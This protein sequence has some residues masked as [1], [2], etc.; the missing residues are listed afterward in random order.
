VTITQVVNYLREKNVDLSMRG[1]RLVV[2]GEDRVVDEPSLLALLREHKQGLIEL[3]QSGVHIGLSKPAVEVPPNQIPAAGCSVI[4]PEMLPLVELSAGQIEALLAKVPGGVTN[5]QDIYPLAPLQE[6]ILFHYLVEGEGDPYLGSGLMAFDTKE[7][8]NRYLEAMQAV[9]NRH[10]ILRTCIFWSGLP[11]PV[12]VVLRSATPQVEEVLLESAG[13]AARQLYAH[14]DPRHF[15]LD[16][17]Q[18]PLLRNFIAYDAGQQRWLLLILQHHLLGDHTTADALMEEVQAHLLGK[19][20]RLPAPLPFRNLVAQARLGVSQEEHEAFFRGMLGD[21]DEPTIPFG[22]LEVQG[23]GNN[24]LE[25]SL[26]LDS[27]LARSMREQTRRLGVSVA[28]LC[29]LAWG[30]VLARVSGRNDVVFGT[31]LFGRMEAGIGGRIM[32]PFINTLPLRLRI[33]SQCVVDGVRDTHTLLAELL[34]HEH[35]PLA[36]AQRCSAV[37]APTPLF[38]ALLNYYR[39]GIGLSATETPRIKGM[40]RVSAEERTNYPFSLS[41]DDLGDGLRLALQVDASIDPA[42]ICCFMQTALQSL[43]SAIEHA[44][45]TALQ[46]LDVLPAEERRQVL[47]GW[48]DTAAEYR[49]DKCVHQLFEEQ[50]ERAPDAVALVFEEQELSYAQLNRQA[51]RLANHL[52]GLGVGPNDRVAIYVERSVAM[53]VAMLAVLKAGGAYVPLDPSYPA[54]RLRF[55]LDDSRPVALLTQSNFADRFVHDKALPVLIF[56]ADSPAWQRQPDNN[57]E[58]QQLTRDHLAYVIYTSGSTGSPKGVMIQHRALQNFFSAMDQTLGHDSS[59]SPW[60]SVTSFSFDISIL[61]I[62][63]PLT[64]GHPIELHSSLDT[65]VRQKHRGKRHLQCTPSFASALVERLGE[66]TEKPLFKRILIGGEKF[67]DTLSATLQKMARNGV[68]NMYGPTETTI[69]SSVYFCQQDA[70]TRSMPIGKPIANTQIYILDARGEPAPIGVAGELHIG[71]DGVARGYLNQPELTAE[72]FLNDPFAAQPG[73]RMYR[74]GDLGRWLPDGN[75][76]LLGRNDFQV[77]LRGFRIELGEIEARLAQH[78]AVREAVV[79]VRE[80]QPGDKRLVAYLVPAD[81]QLIPD[82]ET[83]RTHLSVTLPDYMVPAAYVSLDALPLTPNGKLDRNA[84]A[85]PDGEAYATRGYAPPQRQTETILAAIWSDVLHL[86]RVGRHDNFFDL[87]GHSLL[88]VRVITKVQQVLSS[89]IAIS[90]LFAHPVL[91]DLARNVE[92]AGRSNLPPITLAERSK[93]LPLSFAQQRLWFLAQMDGSSETY[94]IPFRLRLTGELNGTALRSALD[95]IKVRHEAL[96]TSFVLLDGEP[97]QRIAPANESPFLLVEHDL[98]QHRDAHVELARL[99]TLETTAGFFLDAGPLIRGR[100]VRLTHDEYA[101]LITMHHIVSD[102]WSMGIFINELSTLYTA[103]LNGKADPLPRLDI[104]YADYAV[105]QR[106]WIEGD[107]LQRQTEYWKTLADAPALLELAT[108]HPRPAQRN[109]AGASARLLLDEELTAGLKALSARHGTTLF[110]TLLTG[111]AVLLARLSGQKDVVIGTPTANRGRAEIEN[112]IGFFVN[113]LALR[114][115]LSSS[116]TVSALLA[117][118]KARV[119]SAQQHQDIPFEQVVEIAQPARSLAHTPLFQV[120]FVWQNPSRERPT[121]PGLEL[122]L[123]PTTPYVVA[124]FDLTLSLQEAESRITGELEYATSLFDQSTIERYVVYFRTLLEAMAT[125]DS[126]A[127]DRLR[128]LTGA[129]REQLLYGWNDTAADYPRDLCVHQLFEEQ[130]ALAPDAIALLFEGEKLSYAELNRQANQLAHHLRTL[131]VRPDDRIALCLERGFS[132][133]VAI[134]AVLKAGGAYVPLDPAYPADRL[135]FLLDDSQ[136]AA[137]ITQ[138]RLAALFPENSH[139][140]PRVLLLDAAPQ[141][142]RNQPDT[143]LDTA[144]LT[145]NHLAYVIYTSGSTGM[146]KGVLVEH[147]QLAARLTGVRESLAFGAADTMPTVSSAAFDISVLEMLLPLVSGGTTYLTDARRIKDIDYL[148]EQT[149]TATVFNAVTSLMDAW[150]QSAPRDNATQLYPALRTL[151]VGGEPVSQ[152]LLNQLA[153]QFPHTQLVETYGP[154]EATLYCTSCIA[155]PSADT[156]VLPP[157]GHPLPNTKIYILDAQGEPAPIG[158]AGELYIGGAGVARGYLNRPELTAERFLKDPFAAQPGARMYRT[159]DLGRW[160]PDGNIEFLGRN[161]F[162]V[163]L[164]GFRIELGEIEA[165]LAQHPAVRDAIVLVREERLVAYLVPSDAPLIPDAEMLRNHLSATLPDYMV[166]TAYVALNALPL[167]PNGKLDRHALP[168]PEVDAYSTKA[169]EE[170]QGETEALLA[171]IWAD[172]LDLERVGRHDNFFELGGHSLLAITLIERMRQHG[173][174]ADVRTLFSTPTLAQL[175]L[176]PHIAPPQVQVPLNRIPDP[177]A[178][179]NLSPYEV[180]LTI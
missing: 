39:S 7:Q 76:E 10:D 58:V 14:V 55:M 156:T 154:T 6:G 19:Q 102:G 171:R 17:H 95:R 54:D 131:G 79:L 178:S 85:A 27:T 160:L 36:L 97:V 151:L 129:E 51:N 127:I 91:M 68:L 2:S 152:R 112:L 143:N 65:V 31:V 30:I 12:Q 35:A 40:K 72:R 41:V 107:V 98:R 73:A 109:H 172:L 158:V 134:L 71:G 9:V 89:D 64:H 125:R 42:R 146:P 88:A 117:Q 124:N 46:S 114:V 86:E 163:K 119:I 16:L 169:Y 145:P 121:M 81:T 155:Q 135:R 157:I 179:N 96:R 118:V 104:Q 1:D 49:T 66:T 23:D 106:Q 103:F 141:P 133:I 148:L 100:L 170:P 53:I 93:A 5:V 123:L 52:R 56:D 92:N 57:T 48:N 175:A 4:T 140:A 177:S 67:P 105:W 137:L 180:E 21:I 90:D 99:V 15:R 113:T 126:D 37:P 149:R 116:P 63:W 77:K 62:I 87:G 78:S 101:L 44:P 176:P 161:D 22:L 29:H 32:G 60:I 45:E 11:E 110:M 28:S 162:Q 136:P 164:R 20:E 174:R 139:S 168:A 128:L 13:D 138:T 83:L 144:L 69:W 150:R 147:R 18:A 50:V 34:R 122:D 24:I 94:H 166:P 38:S 3:L 115:D 33:G 59:L 75:V 8:L 165:C 26:E 70:D 25:A 61:E 173:L 167:T 82:A 142:W 80:D 43:V 132:M 111:W 84:L 130:V 159:G 120:L 108:D 74:T 153:R 47:Y